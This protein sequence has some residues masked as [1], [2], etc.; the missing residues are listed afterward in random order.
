M[1]PLLINLSLAG[2]IICYN[3]FPKIQQYAIDPYLQSLREESGL[4]EEE[5]IE[6]SVF[7][8]ERD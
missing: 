4:E 1:L 7:S 8:D 2:F 3:S 6:E 5:G